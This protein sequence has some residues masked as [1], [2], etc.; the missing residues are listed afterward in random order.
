MKARSVPA[1]HTPHQ[2]LQNTGWFSTFSFPPSHLLFL[3][4]SYAIQTPTQ[5]PHDR[6]RLIFGFIDEGFN[7]WFAT[8]NPGCFFQLPRLE[9]CH[10]FQVKACVILHVLCI[11]QTDTPV[12]GNTTM[13]AVNTL[14]L[15]PQLRFR[16]SLL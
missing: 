3:N 13:G 9:F 8:K 5:H 2:A 1:G 14:M 7:N 11:R 10:L 12:A 16:W 15:I 4:T 6:D